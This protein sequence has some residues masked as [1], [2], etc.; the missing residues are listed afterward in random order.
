MGLQVWL[1]LNNSLDNQGLDSTRFSGTSVTYSAGKIGYC[2]SGTISGT[3]TTLFSTHGF[4]YSLWWNI[5]DGDSYTITIPITNN[6]TEDTLTFTKMDYTSH[7][8]IKLYCNNNNPQMLWIRD[9]RYSSGIWEL[10]KWHHFTVKVVNS[11]SGIQVLIYVDGALNATYN[12]SSYNFTLR[13]GTIQIKGSAKVNDFRLFN[14]PLSIKEIEELSKG[15]ILHYPLRDSILENTTNYLLYPTPGSA[16]SPAWDASLHPNAINVAGFGNGYNGGVSSPE[17]GYHAYWNVI[18][19]VPTMVFPNLNSEYS[20]TNRWL[21]I[22]SYNTV[23]LAQTIGEGNKYTISFE[24]KASVP[25]K[26]VQFGLYYRKSG[27]TSNAFHDGQKSVNLTTGWKKYSYTWTLGQTPDSSNIGAVYMY[28]HYGI[29][30]IAYV[31]N[32]QLEINDH[33]TEYVNGSRI[34][35]NIYDCSGFGYNGSIVGSISMIPDSARNDYS[36]YTTDG[37]SHYIQSEE[38]LFPTDQITMSC[39]VKG[40]TSGY[41]NY[42][43][44]LSFNSSN[45]EFSLEG[46]TGKLRAGYVINGTRQ[47]VTTSGITVDS[48]W[49]LITSTYDGT[50][51]RRYVDGVEYASTAAVGTLAGGSGRL[52]VG[53]YN[54]TTYGNK[55]LYTS[56]VRIYAT[57]LTQDQ[58]KELYSIGATIDKGGNVYGY[59]FVESGENSVFKEGI[60]DFDEIIEYN[61][62]RIS[63]DEKASMFANSIEAYNYYEF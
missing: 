41:S 20:K 32:L 17:I 5:S 22:S 3:S 46:A 24:A 51:I 1:P 29:E 8:A 26:T 21:G 39:W 59:G 9:N 36:M 18:D 42:H 43:I 13:P 37:R 33:A 40:F 12:S 57:A 63:E 11:D 23:N 30:G 16:A 14:H 34:I 38:M 58:I 50:T 55:E 10:G 54:G 53:N 62:D 44:P 15:L 47:V 48:N 31:R 6:G 4:S 45:Y 52:L 19:G 61:E 7:Y 2:A 25:D 49:H 60:V 56:D 35:S 28:G 27:A